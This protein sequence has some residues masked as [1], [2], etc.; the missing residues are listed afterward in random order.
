MSG[1]RYKVVITD[2]DYPDLSIETPILE[3]IGAQV[4]GA[5]CKTEEELIEVAHDAHGILV[6]YAKVS[7]KVISNMK[8]CIIIARYGVGVDIVDVKAATENGI[9]VTNVPEYCVS[10]VADH[11]VAMF[12]TMA[13]RIREYDSAVREGRWHWE[14]C[15]YK[16]HRIAGMTAG[17]IG[18]G[19]IGKAIAH[20]LKPFG[21]NILVYDP[22]AEK[23]KIE[24]EGCK[25]VPFEELLKNADVIFI[26]AP[27]TEETRGMF[28]RETFSMMKDGAFIVNTARGPIIKNDALYEALASGKLGGAAL[29]DLEEEP[30]KQKN[31]KPTN[32]IFKFGNIVIT[33][34]SAY[35]SEESLIEA[36][37][38]AATEVARALS[39]VLPQNIVNKEVLKKPNLRFRQ[40]KGDLQ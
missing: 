15:G 32:P 37:T 21:L 10:E 6:E 33:P 27:L 7:E 11:A 38:T 30:A 3:E 17:I 4:V 31:W 18:Y 9:I 22:Y 35:Y 23:G 5:Q 2:Y 26:Q 28:D 19:K 13:R 1:P 40:K 39:G 14:A 25:P 34:H 24:N 8:N 36:R 29:D 20:R 16:I 12:L